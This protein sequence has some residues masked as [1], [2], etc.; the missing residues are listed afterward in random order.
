MW[1]SSIEF[2][3]K[4]NGPLSPFYEFF[5]ILLDMHRGV[6][7]SCD[8]D[9]NSRIFSSHWATHKRLLSMCGLHQTPY[10]FTVAG[11]D[12]GVVVLVDASRHGLF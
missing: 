8:D 10:L 5:P 11:K 3:S 12:G 9:E 1:T 4:W 7:M 2:N 6:F